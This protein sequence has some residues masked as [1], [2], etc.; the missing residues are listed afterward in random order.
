[1]T[2]GGKRLIILGGASIL[3]AILTTTASLIVYHN[4]G[5]IYLDRSRPG[6][7]PDKDELD[8]MA[9]DAN[10]YKFSD[11]KGPISKEEIDEYLLE[12]ENLQQKLNALPDPFSPASISNEGLGIPAE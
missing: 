11:E 2:R 12:L 8:N 7:L 6:F 3:I 5:D 10:D 4:S 1:M 9:K